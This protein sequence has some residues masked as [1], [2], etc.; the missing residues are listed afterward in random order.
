METEQQAFVPKIAIVIREDL[1]QWKKLNVTA[2]LVSGVAAT[3]KDLVGL[4][5]EDASKSTYLPMFAH[6]VMVFVSTGGELRRT[7]ERATSRSVPVAIYTN[8]LFGTF[9]DVDN[10]AAVASVAREELDLVGIA[11]CAERKTA[12]K[13]LKGLKLHP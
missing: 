1:E 7:L 5:Y 10:R 2:F 8:D 6:P 13:V 4:A 3:N 9:N 11:F 12:D